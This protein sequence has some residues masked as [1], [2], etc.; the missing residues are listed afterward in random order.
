VDDDRPILEAR[1]RREDLPDPETVGEDEELIGRLTAEIEAGGPITFARFM[2][3]A[4][5]EP[6]HGYYRRPAVGPGRDGDFLTAPEAHPIF[7]AA[8]GRLLEQAWDARGRPAPFTITEPG[9]G[10]SALAAGL[11][12]GLRDL[13]SPMLTR[14]VPPDRAGADRVRDE[15]RSRPPGRRHRR[16]TPLGRAV[17]TGAVV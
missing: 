9:A 16:R 17:E 7:G 3:R 12:G 4:L 6:G 8:I 2:E 15:A 1:I 13:G 11:L 5:Y 14:P 10:A